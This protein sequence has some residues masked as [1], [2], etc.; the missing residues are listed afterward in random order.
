MAV[1]LYSM[2]EGVRLINPVAVCRTLFRKGCEMSFVGGNDVP[3]HRVPD[4]AAIG[5][6]VNAAIAQ[7]NEHTAYIVDG[8]DFDD[9]I[10]W[11]PAGWNHCH[12]ISRPQFEH[13]RPPCEYARGAM[14]KSRPA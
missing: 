10:R 11:R 14:Q 12:T 13:A 4:A 5:E 1:S 6:G 3:A 7:L 9:L 2:V 8:S